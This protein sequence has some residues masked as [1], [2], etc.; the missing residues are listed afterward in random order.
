MGRVGH[1]L[2]GSRGFIVDPW[3]VW[4]MG[5][6]AGGV[7][8]DS[9]VVWVVGCLGRGVTDGSEAPFLLV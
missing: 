4:V 6:L 9:W 2:S 8:V 1:G 7:I 5:C 3:V